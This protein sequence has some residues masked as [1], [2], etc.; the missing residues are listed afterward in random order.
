MKY[1]A[2][3]NEWRNCARLVRETVAKELQAMKL[4]VVGI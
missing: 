1:Q 2:F 3:P 4:A